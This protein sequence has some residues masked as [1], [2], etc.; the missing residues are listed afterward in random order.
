[1]SPR[2]SIL[3]ALLVLAAAFRFWGIGWGTP[4]RDDFYVDETTYVVRHALH[5]S[6]ADPDPQFLN[7]PSFLAYTIA[8]GNGALTRLGVFHERWQAHVLGRCV[9]AAYGSL[10][11][12][13][14]FLTVE[15]MGAP[16][17]GAALAGLWVALLPD[18]IWESHVAVTD[19]MMTFW[20]LLVVLASVRMSQAPTRRHAALCGMALGLAVGS[21][22]TA[23]LAAVAPL[24]ALAKARP[25]PRALATCLVIV[26]LTALAACF[27]VTPYSFLH[28]RE[29]LQALA[30]ENRHVHQQHPGFSMP[31]P[32]PQYHRYLYQLVAAFPFSMGLALY[33]T[34][35]AGTLWVATRRARK[36]AELLL[37]AVCFF[38]LTGSFRFTPLRYYLPITVTL[39]ACAGWWQGDWLASGSKARALV[40]GVSVAAALVYTSVFA[41]QT[42]ERYSHDTRSSVA[43]WLANH[44]RP[45]LRVVA[46]GNPAYLALPAHPGFTFDVVP[47]GKALDLDSLRSY[48]VVEITSMSYLRGYRHQNRMMLGD[49]P[50]LRRG[51]AGFRLLHRFEADFLNRDLYT[52]LDPMFSAYFVSPTIEI[53][54]RDNRPA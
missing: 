48:D 27:A 32:G 4:E 17:A 30:F 43:K 51:R 52:R 31:A 20:T 10:T 40:A 24:V 1:M 8:L 47:N 26:G 29:L 50:R 2:R 37:V 41:F 28:L 22:Y 14:A 6:L 13:L 21:K 25:P 44:V 18:H 19:V 38:A 15:A 49:Y 36:A 9:I 7:Y 54:V 46:V 33:V 39:A 53:Y 45:E 23:A 34:S 3:V 35:I 12:P 42:T 5:V 11:A 16:L